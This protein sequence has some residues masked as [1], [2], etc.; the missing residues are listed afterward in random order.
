MSNSI[1][2]IFLQKETC[3]NYF[4]NITS[5]RLKLLKCQTQSI[6]YQ[7]PRL[8]NDILP[9]LTHH[10]RNNTIT[11]RLPNT[12][13]AHCYLN[14]KNSKPFKR[15]VKLYLM[16]TQGLGDMEQWEFNNFRLYKGSRSSNRTKNSNFSRTDLYETET[17]KLRRHLTA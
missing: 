6:F 5:P 13:T 12:E 1:I 7:G 2:T 16:H 15:N 14:S 3:Y 10:H 4:D 11:S 9:E 8:F 17:T